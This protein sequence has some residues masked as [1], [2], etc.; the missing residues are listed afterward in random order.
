MKRFLIIIL[1]ILLAIIAIC[2]VSIS[3]NSKT[4]IGILKQNKEYEQYFENELYGTDIITLINKAI[5]SNEKNNVEKNEKGL[6]INNNLN[7]VIIDLVM[8]T[9]EEKKRNKNL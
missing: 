8:I 5:D 4:S 3:I 1:I 2:S 9:D 6:F 7:S